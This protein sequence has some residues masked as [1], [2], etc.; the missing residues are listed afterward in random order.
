MSTFQTTYIIANAFS[1]YTIYKLMHVF[2]DAIGTIKV[3]ETLG[4]IMYYFVSTLTFILVPVPFVMLI[5]NLIM[6]LGLTYNY[7]SSFKDRILFYLLA[8]VIFMSVEIFVGVLINYAQTEYVGISAFQTSEFSS[9]MGLVAIRVISML[10]VVYLSNFK[11]LKSNFSVPLVNWLGTLFISLATLFIFAMLLQSGNFGKG[12]G[13]L[14]VAVVLG[15]NFMIL[16]LYENLYKGFKVETEKML[17]EQQ[18]NMY[19]NE[20]RLIRALVE[21]TEIVQ[22]DLKNH[23]ITIKSMVQSEESQKIHGYIDCI[24]VQPESETLYSKTGNISI[25]CIIN[26]KLQAL[27]EYLIVPKVHVS[28]PKDL[29]LSEY[30]I[31]VILGN[32]ID[33][34]L[35]ALKHCK[36]VKKFFALSIV[37]RKGNLFIAVKNSYEG[38]SKRKNGIFLSR[39]KGYAVEGVGLKSVSEAVL[40][41]NGVIEY[42][43]EG[44][45]FEVKIVMPL[46]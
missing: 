31:T 3:K 7:K 43:Y 21:K 14:L 27:S 12:V 41:N 46:V 38:L 25:D 2:F 23:M 26:F 18:N 17:L 4:Y 35:E 39:K 13:V 37:Y 5:L 33:N 34:A 1:T 19:L 20:L 45:C 11:N 44:S 16:F 9:V 30:D 15:I 10:L 22:H 36:V 40:R 6:L 8:Y 24:S 28:V 29:A 42:E 32:L